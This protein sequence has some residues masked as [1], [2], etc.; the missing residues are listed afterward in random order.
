MKNRN[1]NK[2][3]KPTVL[4][5]YKNKLSTTTI[6]QI[7]KPN[8]FKLYKITIKSGFTLEIKKVHLM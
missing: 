4:F 5:R 6:L 1:R 7:F 2:Q 8:K 3:A